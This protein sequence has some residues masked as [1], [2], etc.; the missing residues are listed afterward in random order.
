MS[1]SISDKRIYN[2]SGVVDVV[3]GEFAG[4]GDGL[5]EHFLGELVVVLELQGLVV[6]ANGLVQLAAQMVDKAQRKE[7]LGVAGVETHALFEESDGTLVLLEFA[8]GVG[9][10]GEDGLQHP[11]A[12]VGLAQS[13][14]FL[15]ALPGLLVVLLLVV[16][17]P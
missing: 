5:L 2:E 3:P 14:S 9:Q 11:I 1:G 17:D 10:V 15:V 4:V 8:A 16:D 7:S 13:Q 6:E 12:A